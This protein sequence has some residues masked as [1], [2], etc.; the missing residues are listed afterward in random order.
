MSSP[1]YPVIVGNVRGAQRMLPDTD[2]KA[3]DQP[4]VRA[5]TSGATRTKITMMA[6]VVIYLFGCLRGLIRRVL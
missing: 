1:V 2:W 4:G 5:R 3:E 6:R